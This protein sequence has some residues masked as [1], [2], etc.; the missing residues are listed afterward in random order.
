MRRTLMLAVGLILIARSGLAET[1][2][3]AIAPESTL[4]LKGSSNLAHWQCR[5]TTLSGSM[6]L[7]APIDK[8]NEVIDRIEDGNMSV[9]MSEPAAGRF[10]APRFDLSIPVDSLRCT[11]GR[12]ME[13][14]MRNA[15]KADHNPLIQF[16]F[17]A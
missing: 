2:R 3:L 15:M 1:T 5:G 17:T 7:D 8:I 13:R 12:P 14:D 9:W 6:E 4:L 16:R 10:P 11:G